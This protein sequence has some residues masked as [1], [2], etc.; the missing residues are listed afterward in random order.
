MRPRPGVTIVALTNRL[1]ANNS[2]DLQEYISAASKRGAILASTFGTIFCLYVF[3]AVDPDEAARLP[4]LGIPLNDG[5]AMPL[6]Y[7]GVVLTFASWLVRYRFELRHG[8]A[9]VQSKTYDVNQIYRRSI[10]TVEGRQREL[11]Q[12]ENALR[13]TINQRGAGTSQADKF[14]FAKEN[15][16]GYRL[17]LKDPEKVPVDYEKHWSTLIQARNEY[18]SSVRNT[19]DHRKS[20]IALTD[21]DKGL[22]WHSLTVYVLYPSIVSGISIIAGAALA[23]RSLIDLIGR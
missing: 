12:A 20:L 18:E 13:M 7:A 11:K 23:F 16:E 9:V 19:K 3:G 21:A 14:I 15:D 17:T 10:E 22:R 6:L 5:V 2:M 4:L 1:A 8:A